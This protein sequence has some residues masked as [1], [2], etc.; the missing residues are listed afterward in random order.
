MTIGICGCDRSCGVTHFTIALSNYCASKLR[1]STACAEL[2]DTGAFSKLTS[3]SGSSVSRVS[4]EGHDYISIYG[5]HYYP[6]VAD[7]M[8]PDFTNAGYSCLLFDFGALSAE[9][10]SEFLRCDSKIVI[11]SLAPWKKQTYHSFFQNRH[12]TQKQW[13]CCHYLVLF[14]E[15]TDILKMSGK[16]HHSMQAIPFFQDPFHIRKELFSFLQQMLS[17]TM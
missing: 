4:E 14:G 10:T 9:H 13:E 15:T 11:G 5:V 1:L 6:N 2:N 8:I 12:F 3:F 7:S 16:Y 17:L